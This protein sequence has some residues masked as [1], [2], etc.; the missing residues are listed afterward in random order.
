MF[1]DTVAANAYGFFIHRQ[2][3]MHLSAKNTPLSGVCVA[4]ERKTGKLNLDD[5]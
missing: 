3:E 5:G 4:A 2:I 1:Q